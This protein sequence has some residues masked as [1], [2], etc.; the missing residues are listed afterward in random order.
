[1]VFKGDWNVCVCVIESRGFPSIS[2][3]WR[4]CRLGPTESA[5]CASSV[6]H[7]P[8]GWVMEGFEP[9]KAHPDRRRSTWEAQDAA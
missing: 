5:S 8:E 6:E 9:I 4:I 1:M 2:L 7:H 3:P